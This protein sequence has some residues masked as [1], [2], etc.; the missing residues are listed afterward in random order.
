MSTTTSTTDAAPIRPWRSA[1]AGWIVAAIALVIGVP[2]FLCMPPWVDITL[3][4]MAVR[5]VLRGGVHYRDLFDTN[6]PGIVWSMAGIR[7]LFGWS[8]E[9]LR[10]A[11]LV[12]VAAEVALLLSWV[13]RSGGASYTIAWLAAAAA[14]YYPFTGEFNHAQRDCWLLLPALV[15]ARLRLLRVIGEPGPRTFP[16]AVLEG[17]AWGGAVWIKPHAVVPA[18]CVWLVSAVLISRRESM[19]RVLADLAALVLGGALIG[20]AGV[21]WLIGTGTWP[22]FVDVFLNWNPGYLADLWGTLGYRFVRTFHVFRPWSLLQLAAL[23]LAIL[24]F[25]EVR[26]WSRQP[27][28]LLLFG[29][30]SRFYLPAD[31][32]AVAQGRALLAALYL[33][34]FAQATVLQ[35]G[36]D[37]VQVPLLVLAMAVVATHRWAFGFAYLVWFIALGL[38]LNFTP[39]E[40]LLRGP[41]P[42]GPAVLKLEPYPLVDGEFLESW[43]RCWTDC[44]SPRLRNRLSQF[45]NIHCSPNWNQLEDVAAYL[46]SVRPPLGPGEL[47]CWND[48]THPLY[49]MLDV[50][51][52]TRFMHYGTVFALKKQTALIAAEVAASRQRYVVSDLRRMTWDADEAYAPGAGGDPHRLPPWFPRSQRTAF[53]WNQPIVFRS[54]RYLVHKIERP[55]GPIDVPDWDYLDRLGPGE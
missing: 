53:P 44:G 36:L 47:N 16:T 22:H 49:L 38:L 26:I 6:L 12:I 24:A 14:M 52:A 25:V 50:E 8:Y 33:G 31:S 18:F 15:A 41:D 3:Y 13:R 55:L 54:G 23:P 30:G 29:R 34:F 21:A 10:A 32:E 20:G 43:P 19:T 42:P 48:T 9:A 1:A 4:D 11:D 39:L 2:L 7:L 40:P 27:G 5:N 45:Q 28:K 17:I 46:R 35:K 51:P 37:Y